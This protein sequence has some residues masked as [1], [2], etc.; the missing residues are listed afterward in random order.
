MNKNVIA[1]ILGGGAGTRLS[2]LTSTR[3]K[4]AVPIAGKYRLVDIPISNCLNSNIGRMYVLTQF[5]SAS[6]NKH[7]KN[8]YHFSAFSSAF[9]DIIA[10]EQTPDN[11]AW[12]QG[13]ADAVRQSLRH[14]TQQDFDYVLILSGD[15]LYQMDF[16]EMIENHIHSHA[17]ISIATIPVG[18]QEATEFGIMKKGDDGIISSFIEKPKAEVLS[19]WESDTG[20]AMAKQGR[21]YLASMGI[22]IFGRKVLFDLL[23]D[24][25]KDATDFGKEIIPYS[26]TKHNVVSY[27]YEGYW[28]DIGN[29]HSFFEA[30]LALTQDIPEFNL[31]DNDRSIFTRPRMLPPAKIS[32]TTLEKTIIA[33]G[34]IINASRV[35]HSVLGIRTRI[36]YGTTVVSCYIMGTDFFETLDEMNNSERNGLPKLG[37]GERCYIK[38]AIIDKNCRIGNDVRINGGLHLPNGDHSLYTIKD[39]IVVVKKG[40]VIPNGFVI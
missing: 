23:Q 7:I 18:T 12:F 17:D 10:A 37:I 5:N 30:N 1:I 36:G 29:I 13:T 3:S 31:F 27:Q 4:P 33:E 34:C 35:E 15:Q 16:E 21:N 39:G 11:P 26:I 8:T 19:D 2:P 20:E 32:G 24:E 40:A 6:L 9:V 14:I 22:Y 25:F 38:N 28:T